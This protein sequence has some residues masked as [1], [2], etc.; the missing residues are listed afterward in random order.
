MIGGANID[1]VARSEGPAVLRTSNPGHAGASMGGV[2]RNIAENLARLGTP[3]S[4]VAAVGDDAHGRRL[5]A[6][7]AATGVD[8]SQVRL[9]R[10]ATGLYTA[11]LD[12]TG[13]L[14]V[15]VSDMA[16]TDALD[17]DHVAAAAAL[18]ATA[19][20]VVV[21]GNLALATVD[22]ALVLA[23]DHRR[24][25]IIEPVSVAKA[26]RLAPVL[27]AE[28][29][30]WAIT[31]NRDEL[32]ALSG[33]DTATGEGLRAGVA[34]LHARGVGLVWVRLGPRGSILSDSHGRWERFAAHPASVVDVTGAGDA[35]LAAFVHAHLGGRDPAGAVAYGHAAAAL[36]VA[37]RHTV[38]PD[39]TAALVDSTVAHHRRSST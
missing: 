31:P 19:S 16:A 37:T 39:L 12:N 9:S 36:T 8:T 26:L 18:V 27:S 25:V 15:A 3:V 5:I 29:P 20:V 7:T 22:H 17:P 23:A 14:V 1:V 4:L 28:R 2:G 35:M 21:D 6:E 11:V 10:H 30:L 33:E 24:K 34:A 32:G 13:E 38:R